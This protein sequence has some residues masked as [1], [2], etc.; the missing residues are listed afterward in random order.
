M[1]LFDGEGAY[2]RRAQ[3]REYVLG[4]QGM[5]LLGLKMLGWVKETQCEW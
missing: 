5:A 1:M 2:A 4:V 3:L